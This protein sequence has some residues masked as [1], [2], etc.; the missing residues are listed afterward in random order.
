MTAILIAI[1]VFLYS[2]QSL[3]CK[4]FSEKHDCGSAALTSTVFSIC[5]GGVAG[6][7]TLVIN[8]FRI[9]P[10]NI[11]LICGLLNAVMLL[12]YNTAMVQAS[13]TGSYSFQMIC[14][15]FGGS[16]LPMIYGVLFLNGS[17]T[18]LQLIAIAMMLVSFVLMNLKGLSLKGSS[19]KF[20]FWCL[21]L[22]MS[23]GIYSILMNV[24]QLSMEGAQRNEM[25]ILSYLG[26][27]VLYAAMQLCKDQ[28]ALVQGFKIP[29]KPLLY[30]AICCTSATIAVHM[31][32][33][34]LTLVEEATILYTIDNGGVLVLSVL[35]SCILFKEKLSKVQ[36]IGIIM[37]TAG[38]V[39]LSI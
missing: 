6:F 32:M 39:M 4:M 28:K 15:L 20:L 31:I 24:Q 33:Y 26:M 2:L 14:M 3:F 37:A 35:Y 18:A 12:I 36:I 30:L 34:I 22:F 21:T 29:K 27:A 5:F 8:G 23:N 38:I 7:A 10:S 17:F 25:I 9:A 1:L 16:V 13:R 11:T 19:K